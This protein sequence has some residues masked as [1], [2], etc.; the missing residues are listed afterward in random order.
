MLKKPVGTVKS[1]LFRAREAM[2]ASLKNI[3][4]DD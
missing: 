1:R 4:G 3:R 2:R